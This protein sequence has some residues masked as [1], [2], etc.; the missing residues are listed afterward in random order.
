MRPS[1]AALLPLLA[2]SLV[3]PAEAAATRF[4]VVRRDGPRF[5]IE[6]IEVAEGRDRVLTCG[7]GGDY[8]DVIFPPSVGGSAALAQAAPPREIRLACRGGRPHVTVHFGGRTYEMEPIDD[9]AGA[10]CRVS[11]VGA[12]GTLQAFLLRGFATAE[13]DT[14]GPVADMFAGRVPMQAGDVVVCT[15]TWRRRAGPAARGRMALTWEQYLSAPVRSGPAAGTGIVD[16][17]AGQTVVARAFLPPGTT[18]TP[19]QM[20]RYTAGALELMDYST[21]GATGA[22]SGFAEATLAELNVGGVV[23]RDV[24]VIVMETLPTVGGRPLSAIVGLDLLRRA[25]ALRLRYPAGPGPASLELADALPPA[26]AGQPLLSLPFALVG[27]HLMIRGT[28]AGRSGAFLLDS[29]SPTTFLDPPFAAAAGLA[30]SAPD[31]PLRGLGGQEL[32]SGSTTLPSLAF[33]GWTLQQVPARVAPLASFATLHVHDQSVGLLGNDLL[34]RFG[35]LD[36]DFERGRLTVPRAP[37][38]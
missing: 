23:F 3:P 7:R 12:D 18:T 24:D 13:E 34:A 6:A 33:A 37:L 22:V 15:D 30:V 21:G 2:C 9:P 8:V 10:D 36:I 5:R 16:L 19:A 20:A 38:R 28:V 32:R 1:L 11:L 29:G 26:A 31:R 17:A 25:P 14:V 35:Q 27:S 4:H